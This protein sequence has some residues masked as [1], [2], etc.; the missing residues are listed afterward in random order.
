ML[1]LGGIRLDPV[2]NSACTKAHAQAE[3]QEKDHSSS[4]HCQ[5]YHIPTCI[6]A[7]ARYCV[8]NIWTLDYIARKVL[9]IVQDIAQMKLGLVYWFFFPFVHH[10]VQ[11]GNYGI[12]SIIPPSLFITFQDD[13]IVV[14]S[15]RQRS[16]KPMKPLSKMNFPIIHKSIISRTPPTRKVKLF[17]GKNIK[18]VPFIGS[19]TS[20][21]TVTKT[22]PL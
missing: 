13:G 14:Q 6:S 1:L 18:R 21:P 9:N 7:C 12:C 20:F 2:Q 4:V 8:T 11:G 22:F 10:W 17:L 3:T 19:S 16:Y 5:M 15:R